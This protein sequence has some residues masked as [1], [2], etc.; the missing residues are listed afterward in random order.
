[1]ASSSINFHLN[2]QKIISSSREVQL[3]IVI[4][5]MLFMYLKS[6]IGSMI[7]LSKKHSHVL[8][9]IK[10]IGTFI[11]TIDATVSIIDFKMLAS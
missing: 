1:M 4:R 9:R 6:R 8:C 11:T 3:K 5:N 2:Q 10:N 7:T